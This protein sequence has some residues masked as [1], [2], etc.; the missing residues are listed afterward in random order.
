MNASISI[1]LVDD[2]EDDIFFAK[3]A[4]REAQITNPYKAA[5][6]GQEAIDYLSGVGKFTDRAQFPLPGVM[7]L[8]LKMPRKT[9]FE[10][11]QWVRGE[12]HLRTL[13]I[14]ILTTSCET[15]DIR[16]AYELGANSYLQKPSNTKVLAEMMNSL[17]SYW[18][19]YNQ[20]LPLVAV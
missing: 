12:A 4:L 11:L 7:L 3:H 2:N 20:F 6:D 13:P 10:V 18:L 15:S 14:I 16:R 1:L 19:H 9:G 5:T 8:D 17:K